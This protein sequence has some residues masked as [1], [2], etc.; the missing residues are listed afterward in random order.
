MFKTD[1]I[2]SIAT[3]TGN[4]KAAT[5]LFLDSFVETILESFKSERTST[6]FTLSFLY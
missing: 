4:T 5:E 1:L 2:N 6:Y 3:K